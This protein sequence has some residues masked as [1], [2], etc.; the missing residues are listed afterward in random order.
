M[1]RSPYSSDLNPIEH[2]WARLKELLHEK[3][4]EAA[5]MTAGAP[6]KKPLKQPLPDV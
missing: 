3:F 4:L 2:T 1:K 5:T 6:L